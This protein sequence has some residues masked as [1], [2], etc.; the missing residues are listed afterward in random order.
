MKSSMKPRIVTRLIAGLIVVV[1]G[2]LASFCVVFFGCTLLPGTMLC[3]HNTPLTMILGTPF[4]WLAL[5]AVMVLLL[6]KLEAR[7]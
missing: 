6:A 1:L 5:G 4:A 3:G 2:P 7:S